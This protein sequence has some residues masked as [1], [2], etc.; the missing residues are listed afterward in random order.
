MH[1][2]MGSGEKLVASFVNRWE[3][4]STITSCTRLTEFG[5]GMHAE[6]ERLNSYI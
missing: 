1:Q 3:P 4:L 2:V 6:S 5:I